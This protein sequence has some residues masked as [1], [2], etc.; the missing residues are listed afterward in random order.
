MKI[1]IV[2]SG[3]GG[4]LFCG[5]SIAEEIKKRMPDCELFFLGS[6]RRLARKIVEDNGFKFHK[7]YS[8]GLTGKGLAKFIKFLFSQF[9]GVLQSGLLFLSIKPKIIISAGGFAA[10]GV[11]LW[12]RIYKV[13]CVVHEQNIIPGKANRLAGRFADKILISFEETKKYFDSQK[14]IFTGMP[15]RFNEKIP[16][17]SARKQLGLTPD[18]FTVLVMGGS[19]GAHKI[20]DVMVNALDKLPRDTQFIHLTGVKDMSFVRDAY[21]K[22]KFDAYVEAFCTEM[23]TVYSASSAVICRAGSGTLSEIMF[24][25][26]PGILIPYPYSGDRHQYKNADFVAEKG[27]AVVVAEDTLSPDV[28]SG[29]ISHTGR[30]KLCEMAEKSALLANPHAVEKIVDEV[31]EFNN[32]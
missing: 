2:S 22:F 26:L 13:P 8:S 21:R 27:A 28:L 18:L 30:K 10:T 14:C 23:C 3:T 19:A 29:L 15:V 16:A 6:G 4:H 24:F 7:I 17:C 1:I 32:K 5:L 25:G 20:N 11:V 9:V 12:S 31:M